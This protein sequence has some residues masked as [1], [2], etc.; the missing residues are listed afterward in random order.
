[1]ATTVYNWWLY[2]TYPVLVFTEESPGITGLLMAT[3][4]LFGLLVQLA[5]LR[6][7]LRTYRRHTQWDM[8]S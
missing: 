1:M 5:A 2:T 4:L 6:L 3:A 8:P 7:I